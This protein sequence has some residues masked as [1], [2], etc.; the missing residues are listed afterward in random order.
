MNKYLWSTAA[1]LFLL[2]T[3]S[4]T[5]CRSIKKRSPSVDALGSHEHGDNSLEHYKDKK[6]VEVVFGVKDA[7][8]GFVFDKLNKFIDQKTEWIDHLDRRNIIKNKAH[9]IEPPKD[10]VVSLSSILSNAIG[11][12]LEAAAP[13]LNIVTSK[14][15]SGSGSGSN[16][17][18][19]N[20]GALLGHK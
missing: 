17:G 1:V 11:S 7:I 2:A 12:K 6:K 13:L 20:F 4:G 3:L 8:L 16:H 5:E 9:G 15:G 14:L 10:P 19:F 18:G